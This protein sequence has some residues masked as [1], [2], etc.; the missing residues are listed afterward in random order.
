[1]ISTL[2]HE[3]FYFFLSKPSQLQNFVFPIPIGNHDDLLGQ[4]R[5]SDLTKFAVIFMFVKL[6]FSNCVC[7]PACRNTVHKST[8]TTK[9]CNF[10]SCLVTGTADSRYCTKNQ[11]PSPCL[12]QLSRHALLIRVFCWAS[13][14]LISL[15][16]DG[17]TWTFCKK[18]CNSM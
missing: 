11:A 18:N 13:M 16:P 6:T 17:Q 9:L 7:E 4:E 1:M 12:L 2:I 10:E 5:T 15:R 3:T 14:R 8:R